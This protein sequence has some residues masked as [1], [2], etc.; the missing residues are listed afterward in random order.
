MH[1]RNKIYKIYVRKLLNTANNDNTLIEVEN[2][3]LINTVC[4][5]DDRVVWS[6]SNGVD[7]GPIVDVKCAIN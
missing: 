4:R 3:K 7:P 2:R 1:L 6:N 5:D